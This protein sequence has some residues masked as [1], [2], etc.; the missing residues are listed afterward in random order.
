MREKQ[1]HM[2]TVLSPPESFNFSR[3]QEW[4][5]WIRRFERFRIAAELAKKDT[6]QHA[7]LYNGR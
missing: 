7:D 4:P 2:M 5:K 1:S 3:P 6:G